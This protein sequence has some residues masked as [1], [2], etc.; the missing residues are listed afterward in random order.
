MNYWLLKTEPED[1]SF[2]DLKQAGMDVWDGVRNRQAQKNIRAMSPGD[3]AFIYHT[4]NEK[5]I[6]GVAEIVS[7]PF[8]D[9][10]D[11]QFHAVNVRAQHALPRPVTLKEIKEAPQFEKWALVRQPRLSVMPVSAKH[12]QQVIELSK[13]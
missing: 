5:A 8:S 10:T 7:I 9:P 6:V 3:Q 11:D 4:G 12:W 2:A 13:E 1:Y